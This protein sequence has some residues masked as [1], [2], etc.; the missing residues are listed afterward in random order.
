MTPSD[1]TGLLSL[2]STAGGIYGGIR[3]NDAQAEAI[4]DASQA[5]TAA[6]NKAIDATAGMFNKTLENFEPYR[7]TGLGALPYLNSAAGIPGQVDANG[8]AVTYNPAAS[9]AAKYAETTGLRSLNRQLAGRGMLGGGGA[10][11]KA[12]ELSA[13]V[14]ADDWSKGYGRLL[15]LVKIGAGAAG[16]A[17]AAS[18]QQGT[19]LANLYTNQGNVQAGLDLTGGQNTSNFY[20]GLGSLPFQGLNTYLTGRQTGAF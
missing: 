6:T 16:Q 8:N 3:A 5:N 17:G 19:N 13:G 4:R 18:Q 1:A 9:P 10:A 14:A 15:D 20:K 7:Q 2:L 12:G 11:L